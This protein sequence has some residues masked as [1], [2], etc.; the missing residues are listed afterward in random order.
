MRSE[1]W[2][3]RPSEDESAERMKQAFPDDDFGE[4]EDEEEEEDES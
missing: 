3:G 2:S 4:D 1:P